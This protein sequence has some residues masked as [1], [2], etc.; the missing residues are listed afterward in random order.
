MKLEP[1]ELCRLMGQAALP[2][3]AGGA[4]KVGGY[5]AAELQALAE[6]F[7][8]IQRGVECG[9][10]SEDEARYLF[11]IHKNA[12]EAVL[13]TVEGLGKLALE[14]A[15][16]ATLALVKGTVNRALGFALV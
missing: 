6:A 9:E 10:M 4:A 16:N 14:N 1:T 7:C 11:G 12:L 3:L 13:L 8:E 2:T 15:I 5:A